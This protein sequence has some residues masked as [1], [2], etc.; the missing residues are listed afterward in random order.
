M[1]S[2]TC[3]RCDIAQVHDRLSRHVQHVIAAALDVAKK[4]EPG[5]NPSSQA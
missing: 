3:G 1:G 2:M 5:W 4:S